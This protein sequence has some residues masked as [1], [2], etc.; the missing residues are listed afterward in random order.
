MSD[1]M[2][3]IARTREFGKQGLLGWPDPASH[4]E[5]DGKGQRAPHPSMILGAGENEGPEQ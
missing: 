1:T 2:A 4:G 3:S 5:Q